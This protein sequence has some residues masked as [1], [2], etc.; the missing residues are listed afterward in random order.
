[1][2]AFWNQHLPLL[3]LVLKLY[4]IA[5]LWHHTQHGVLQS[6]S[7]YLSSACLQHGSQQPMGDVTWGG[8]ASG[9]RSLRNKR[10]WG[11]GAALQL[12]SVSMAAGQA[13]HDGTWQHEHTHQT[14]TSQHIYRHRSPE[15]RWE[16]V[17]NKR[18]TQKTDV[19]CWDL[20]ASAAFSPEP[21]PR[22]QHPP[23][24]ASSLT[25][26]TDTQSL[27]FSCTDTVKWFQW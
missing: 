26:H 14:E 9:V 7:R 20:A 1:M 21:T 22:S 25:Q 15:M 3:P 18:A 17:S 16:F 24:H 4:V 13:T 10:E 19:T 6:E 12:Q 23:G 8:T 2:N 27:S 11:N 5:N